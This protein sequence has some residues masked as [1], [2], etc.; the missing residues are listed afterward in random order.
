MYTSQSSFTKYGYT[1][2]TQKCVTFFINTLDKYKCNLL[3]RID[4]C[5]R[6]VRVL[7]DSADS[8]LN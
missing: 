3:I 7:V 2:V 8:D 5:L 1:L 6:D 4:H